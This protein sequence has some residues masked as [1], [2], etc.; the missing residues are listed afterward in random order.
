MYQQCMAKK[1]KT[2]ALCRKYV[3][4]PVENLVFLRITINIVNDKKTR[5]KK[6][7]VA[8]EGMNQEDRARRNG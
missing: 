6:R 5:L 2:G 1:K 4:F 8:R 7:N 3:F